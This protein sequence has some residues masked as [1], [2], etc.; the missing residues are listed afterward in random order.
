MADVVVGYYTVPGSVILSLRSMVGTTDLTDD[1]L[2][3]ILVDKMYED[4][5]FN[6]NAAAAHVWRIKAAGF[7]ELVTVS[8]SGSSRNLSD[9]HKNALSMAAQ[10]EGL[11]R[12]ED[13]ILAMTNRS[14]T[15]QIVRQ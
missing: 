10:F 12:A 6:M 3:A 1:Q 8:E 5:T 11:D 9:M 15:R 7:A 14:R 4:D 2:A 13:P